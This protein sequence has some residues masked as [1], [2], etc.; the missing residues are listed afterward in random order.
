MPSGTVV[1]DFPASP[2]KVWEILADLESA[3]GWVPDLI[4]VTKLDSSPVGVGSQFEQVMNVQGRRTDVKVMIKEF[5]A[6]RVIAH[7]GKGKSL[8]INGRATIAETS[9]GCTVTNEW[10]LE[11]SGLLKLAAPLAGKWTKNNIEQSMNALREKL[12]QASG[13]G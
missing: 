10:S 12:K 6:P 1:A 3:P 9:T 4:S 2:V 11:L 8:K 13:S 7:S 5:D